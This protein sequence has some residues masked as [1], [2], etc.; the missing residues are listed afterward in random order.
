MSIKIHSQPDD[1][2]CGATCLHA[3]YQHYGINLDLNKL[4]KKIGNIKGGGTLAALLG[5]N[6]LKQG[7]KSTIYT[8]NFTVFDCSWKNLSTRDLQRKLSK[9]A[10]HTKNRK[11]LHTIE[12]SLKFLKLGGEIKFE[13]LDTDF[14]RSILTPAQ[15]IITGLCSTYLYDCP[16][17]TFSNKGIAKYDDIKG[18]LTGHFIIADNIDS[19]DRVS[20][21]DPF[22]ANPLSKDNYYH[23]SAQKFINA[24]N[25][26]II[27]HDANMLLISPQ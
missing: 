18:E 6:A 12:A 19:K 27:S 3:I 11:S 26:A 2:S 5:I 1:I 20:I 23:V 17:E 7:C 21:S 25:L 13:L 14:L 4:I 8:W 10:K 16:R 24:I 22:G 15:P 9:H